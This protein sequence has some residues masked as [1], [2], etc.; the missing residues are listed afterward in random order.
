MAP[1][2][3]ISRSRAAQNM[4]AKELKLFE[5]SEFLRSRHI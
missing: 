2:F 4:P 3:A 1:F 5:R